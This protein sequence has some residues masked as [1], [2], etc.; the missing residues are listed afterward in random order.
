MLET[1]YEIEDLKAFKSLLENNPGLLIIK[2]GAEWCKPCNKIKD[3]VQQWFNKMP[4]TVQTVVVD[5][6]VSFEVYA[7]LSNKKMLSGI[8][9]IL[10]YKQGNLNYVF[11]ECVN[12][13]KEEDI[14]LFFEKCVSYI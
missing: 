6:D 8:P 3:Q 7:Y 5:V 1:I 11:D 14:D 12:T 4:D 9:G 2:F 10:M 13:S